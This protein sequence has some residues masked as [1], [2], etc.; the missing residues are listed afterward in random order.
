MTPAAT[1]ARGLE[2][3]GLTLPDD[4]TR[5]L[6]AYVDLLAKWNRTYNLTAIR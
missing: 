4:A 2:G 3:L 6:L 5:R 1:L